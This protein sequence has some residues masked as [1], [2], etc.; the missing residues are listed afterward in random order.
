[1][2]L[3]IFIALGCTVLLPGIAAAQ[4]APSDDSI[5]GQISAGA[6]VAPSYEGSDKM[7][8]IPFLLGDVQYRGIT[9]QLRGLRAQVDLASDPRFSIGPVIGARLNRHNADGPIGPLSRIGTAIE[10]GGFVGYRFGGDALGQGSIQ[11]EVSLVHDVSGTYDGLVATG[12]VGYTVLRKPDRFLAVNVQT[13][14]A[15]ADYTRTYFGITPADATQSGFAAYR[16]G[17]G[18]K[19]VGAG[20]TAGYSLSRHWGLTGRVG[21]SYLVGDAADSPITQSGSR[22]QPL[23][24]LTLSYRF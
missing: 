23:A 11:T 16:P 9:L 12:S 6:G 14:W 22:W 13:T 8:A 7:R 24:G 4:E 18:F 20:L 5:H 1:M 19:D 10:A 3:P 17:A 15:D 21:A 2:R